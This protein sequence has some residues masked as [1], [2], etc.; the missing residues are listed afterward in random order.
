[1]F[2]S[3]IESNTQ[4][5]TD[6]ILQRIGAQSYYSDR[7]GFPALIH[8]H[9]Y[10]QISQKYAE[11]W[12]DHFEES[13]EALSEDDGGA[14]SDKNKAILLDFMRYTAY[15]LVAAQNLQRDMS[16]QGSTY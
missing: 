6:Y 14:V 3:S 13:L 12:L 7:K 4:N 8:R 11:K 1:M 9:T 2:T 10:F 5:L 15:Y 16:K